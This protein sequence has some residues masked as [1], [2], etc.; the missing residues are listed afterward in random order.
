MTFSELTSGMEK[1]EPYDKK[2]IQ[3]LVL[4]FVKDANTTHEDLVRLQAVLEVVQFK[5]LGRKEGTRDAN[6]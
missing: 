4:K 6:L 2:S 1:I 5:W 3:E